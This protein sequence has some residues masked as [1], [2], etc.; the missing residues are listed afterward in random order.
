MGGLVLGK[1]C[2]KTFG[3]KKKIILQKCAMIL[4][5]PSCYFLQQVL[6]ESDAV[7]L[8]FRIDLQQIID[9]VRN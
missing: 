2:K 1:G 4:I 7:N 6:D 8:D 5:L 3:S 9:V